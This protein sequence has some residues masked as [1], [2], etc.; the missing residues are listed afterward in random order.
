MSSRLALG[1]GLGLGALFA[2]RV[3]T[4]QEV[5][6]GYQGLPQ[7]ATGESSTGIQVSDG[8]L[9]HVGTGAEVGYDT[10]V[11]YTSSSGP[12]GS[13]API[14]SG[15]IRANAYGEL[16]NSTRTGAVPSGIFFDGRVN[17]LYRHYLTDDRN[18]DPFRNSFTPGVGIS[19]GLNSGQ[20]VSFGLADTYQ[21]FED[22]PYQPG[23]QVIT[24]D[25]N[26]ASAEV[27]WSPGGGRITATVRYTNMVDI[28]ENQYSYANSDT[29]DLMLDAAWK[30]LPKT[31]VFVQVHQGYV[32]YLN[33][34][35]AMA[36]NKASLY[37][38]RA[39][40]GLRGL[41]T[42][43]ISAILT[44][45]YSNAF[46]SSGTTTGGF[47]GSSF[48]ELQLTYRPTLLSRIVAGYIHDFQ[49][50]VISAFYYDD[51][52]YASYVQ[53]IAGRFAFDLS[54]RYHHKNFQGYIDRTGTMTTSPRTDNTF[55]VGATFDYFIRN[56]IYAG[57]GYSLMANA[58]DYRLPNPTD[59]NNPA[60]STP[61]SYL[62]QQIFARLGVT[63]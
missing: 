26:Q 13:A 30:W 24:R 40:G 3:A 49:N 43:K 55:Q 32:T 42:E 2:A 17:L 31:A 46:Y 21:R 22:A 1:I 12:P 53:Q 33:S 11:F 38:L 52:V 41:I 47:L 27:R 6:I 34:Q 39:T 48:L 45:G 9:M 44:V 15:I 8:V 59:P 5:A 25:N 50:S 57:V 7:K 29:N 20:T 4:A 35:A 54:G 16:T 58:S 14:G 63:Y 23:Q 61:V 60:L 56:W 28:F 51:Q 10:N 36:N 18:V 37:P 62:K 19:L